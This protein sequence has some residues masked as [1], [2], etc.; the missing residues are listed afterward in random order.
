MPTLTLQYRWNDSEDVL[1]PVRL[2]TTAT[3]FGGQRWSLACRLIVDGVACNRRVGKLY[4]PPGARYFGCRTC[5][6]LTYRSCHQAHQAERLA[7][8]LARELGCNHDLT[9]LLADRSRGQA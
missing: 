5:H 9:Q 6:R 8:M 3:Q 2:Q 1:I 7:G 4:L